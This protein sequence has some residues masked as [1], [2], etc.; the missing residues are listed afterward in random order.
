MPTNT[1]TESKRDKVKLSTLDIL[2]SV[3][4]ALLIAFLL[5][6]FPILAE[7]IL[8]SPVEISYRYTS[9]YKNNGY[10][11]SI[12]NFSRRPIDEVSIFVDSSDGVGAISQDGA[13]AFE[14]L[15]TSRTSQIKLKTIPPA[16]ETIVFL[17]VRAQ[18]FRD[19]IRT[20][21]SSTITSFK[22][23]TSAERQ[24][25]D[26][27]TFFNS[28]FT[29]LVYLAFALTMTVQRKQLASETE[30]LRAKVEDLQKTA[31]SGVEDLRAR[32]MRTR[33]YM[34]RRI[35]VLNEEVETWR[36]FFRA[37]YSSVFSG[38]NESEY[39][40]EAILKA[41]GVKMTKRLREYSENE[42]LEILDANEIASKKNL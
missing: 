40:L 3:S 17:E 27:T 18:L 4:V 10:L 34:Q 25:W 5:Y 41:S 23:T 7:Q 6:W 1:K 35:I 30:A 19:Q 8:L 31:L 11:F 38:K 39:A 32:L 37:I 16:K 26:L 9:L 28:I 13:V 36:R 14:I 2:K 22:D 42:F 29:A 20:S 24:F 21:S 33:V 12:K 15:N